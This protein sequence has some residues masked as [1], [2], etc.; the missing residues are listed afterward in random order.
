LNIPGISVINKSAI[1]VGSLWAP[2][3]SAHALTVVLD[4]S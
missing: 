4:R 3:A 2:S 1:D